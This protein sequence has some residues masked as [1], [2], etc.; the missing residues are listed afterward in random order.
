M[1]GSLG[2][3]FSII[4][5]TY[6][7]LMYWYVPFHE[8]I[9]LQRNYRFFFMFISTSTILCIYIFVFS[10]IHI[11]RRQDTVLDAIKHDYLSDFLIVYCFVAV[12][13]VGGLTAF[14]LYLI[15]TNQVN[16][17][18]VDILVLSLF[19]HTHTHTHTHTQRQKA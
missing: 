16:L 5:R 11:I 14:H 2:C 19:T 1:D 4:I 7:V 13:F 17:P 15:C 9:M 3:S 12:W 18:A 8:L 10:W 6:G